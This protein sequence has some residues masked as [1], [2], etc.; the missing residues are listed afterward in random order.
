MKNFYLQ[1]GAYANMAPSMVGDVMNAVLVCACT[2]DSPLRSS[3]CVYETYLEVH[4]ESIDFHMRFR[5]HYQPFPH[6]VRY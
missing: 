2:T 1:K 5:I 4:M 3:H 6:F